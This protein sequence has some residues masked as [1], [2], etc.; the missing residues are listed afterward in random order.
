MRLF[1]DSRKYIG[2]WCRSFI[3][4]S[5]RRVGG[6]SRL[7]SNSMDCWLRSTRKMGSVG[8]RSHK[9]R[10]RRQ[11]SLRQR[12]SKDRGCAYWGNLRNVGR[13]GC[14]KAE[15]RFYVLGMMF[16]V[17]SEEV[18]HDYINYLTKSLHFP[19]KFCLPCSWQAFLSREIEKAFS[20]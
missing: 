7:P 8:Q 17:F 16:I 18:S 6:V 5:L 15:S 19:S 14:G 20:T 11:M 4:R 13:H 1:E 9:S 3:G 12:P 10:R 2:L